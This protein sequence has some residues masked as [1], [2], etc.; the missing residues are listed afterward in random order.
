MLAHP[1][2]LQLATWSVSQALLVVARLPEA[3]G[4]TGRA[5]CTYVLCLPQGSRR[6][7]PVVVPHRQISFPGSWPAVPTPS[8]NYTLRE[9]FPYAS[10]PWGRTRE[11]PGGQGGGGH[12]ETES[13][14]LHRGTGIQSLPAC[15]GLCGPAEL[16]SLSEPWLLCGEPCPYKVWHLKP[17]CHNVCPNAAHPG[18][19]LCFIQCFSF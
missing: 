17:G 9:R 4:V 1:A 2:C 8:F 19:N 12:T 14:V 3:W 7:A 16:L 13:Q 11:R 15:L 18:A 5:C 10:L 6:T